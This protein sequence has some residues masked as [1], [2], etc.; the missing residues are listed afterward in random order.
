MS[1]RKNEREK[2]SQSSAVLLS[3][4]RIFSAPHPLTFFVWRRATLA[5]PQGP[6]ALLALKDP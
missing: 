1:E 5:L 4:G 6:R 3:L 2:R